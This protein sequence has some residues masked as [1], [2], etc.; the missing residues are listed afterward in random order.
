MIATGNHDFERF[1]ALCDTLPGEARALRARAYHSSDDSIP[2]ACGRL[3]AAATVVPYFANLH[4]PNRPVPFAGGSTYSSTPTG[5]CAKSKRVPFIQPHPL[6]QPVWAASSPRGGA[7]GASRR[8]FVAALKNQPL[9]K[10]L[11]GWDGMI[12]RLRWRYGTR[13]RS[14]TAWCACCRDIHE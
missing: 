1:A 13:G 11:V 5:R 9:I 6:S 7:E 14:G 8:G 3:V 4:S 10:R 12:I 2:S